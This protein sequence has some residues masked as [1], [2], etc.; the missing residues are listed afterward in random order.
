MRGNAKIKYLLDLPDAVVFDLL[1]PAAEK[2]ITTHAITNIHQSTA[3]W[4]GSSPRLA[5]FEFAPSHS[6]IVFSGDNH[7]SITIGIK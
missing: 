6:R 5:C 1:K 7:K 2:I 4:L 3:D